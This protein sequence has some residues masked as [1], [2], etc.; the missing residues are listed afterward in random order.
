MKDKIKK[1]IVVKNEKWILAVFFVMVIMLIFAGYGDNTAYRGIWVL[2][3]SFTVI[4]LTIEFE[5]I[6]EKTK[7]EE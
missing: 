4:T 7:G 1:T 3:L 5:I 2:F 6:E